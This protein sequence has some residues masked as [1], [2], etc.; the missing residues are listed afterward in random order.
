MRDALHSVFGPSLEG[1]DALVMAAAVGDYR[2]A[3]QQEAKMKRTSDAMSL[4]LVP[5]PDLL[6]ELGAQRTGPRPVLV[7]FAVETAQEDELVDLA[8]GKLTRKRVDLVVGNAARVAFGGESNQATLV[9]AD[10]V[11]HLPL[12]AKDALADRILDRVRA[13]LRDRST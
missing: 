7:G 1:A 9:G 3:T 11:D 5:N 8:R 13:K 6:A 2:P 4:E 12:M 10:G